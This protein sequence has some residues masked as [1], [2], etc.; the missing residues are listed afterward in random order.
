MDG[1]KQ[2]ERD[3]K[4]ANKRLSELD[5][6]FAKLFESHAKEEISDRNFSTLAASYEVEQKNL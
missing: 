2:A 4:K 3:L 5:R 1:V 6:L